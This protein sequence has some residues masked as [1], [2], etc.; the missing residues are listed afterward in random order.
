M[1]KDVQENYLI[2]S[3]EEDST[4]IIIQRG[5]KL[6]YSA[7]FSEGGTLQIDKLIIDFFAREFNVK[8]GPR[9]AQSMRTEIGNAVEQQTVSEVKI[10]AREIGSDGKIHSYTKIQ[11]IMVTDGHIRNAISGYLNSLVKEVNSVVK[12]FELL[13]NTTFGDCKILLR[14]KGSSLNGLDKWLQGETGLPVI[15]AYK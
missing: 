15:L 11:E 6:V 3:I 2:V 9:T 12:Q 1:L 5:Q 8:I 4:R 13:D 14:G 7:E 10:R